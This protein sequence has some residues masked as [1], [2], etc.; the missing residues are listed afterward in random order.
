[1][2]APSECECG[3]DRRPPLPPQHILL[4]YMPSI[5]AAQRD[6]GA[7]ERPRRRRRR[8]VVRYCVHVRQRLR[9]V[10]NICARVRVC[11]YVCAHASV[12]KSYNNPSEIGRERREERARTC[13]LSAQAVLAAVGPAGRGPQHFA[14]PTSGFRCLLTRVCVCKCERRSVVYVCVC[15]Y[16][17]EARPS[18]CR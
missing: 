4:R 14:R 8:S 17:S 12:S 15:V 6:A 13:K 2:C 9:D 10:S 11:V 7:S 1:M 16:V 3:G 18:K 5:C